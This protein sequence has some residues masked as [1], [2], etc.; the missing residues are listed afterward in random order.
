MESQTDLFKTHR[1]AAV[2]SDDRKHRYML[3]RHWNTFE[4]PG[5]PIVGFIGLN[6][7]TANESV[8]D[9]TIRKVM[10]IARHNGYGGVIMMNL[11]SIVSSDPSVLRHRDGV[12]HER[13]DMF[14]DLYSKECADI[15]FAWGNFKEAI[16]RAHIIVKKFPNALCLSVNNNGSP[17]HPLYCRTQS[18][19]IHFNTIIP[20]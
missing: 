19:L 13:N 4:M 7:S 14:I 20:K 1:R 5:K 18:P 12:D 6:P 16:E 2:F 9:P 11:F 8:D 17:K 10:A 15:V 3:T